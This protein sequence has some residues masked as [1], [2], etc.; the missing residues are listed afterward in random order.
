MSEYNIILRFFFKILELSVTEYLTTI[1]E[2]YG[3]NF[4]SFLWDENNKSDYSFNK[5]SLR[6]IY[7]RYSLFCNITA[8]KK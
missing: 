3:E 6:D 7:S 5:L 2:Y 8:L 4:G 1:C